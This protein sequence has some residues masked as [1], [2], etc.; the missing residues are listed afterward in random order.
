MK[1]EKPL[2]FHIFAGYFILVVALPWI[3]FI[4]FALAYYHINPFDSEFRQE[5][6][7]EFFA[8][9]PI[10][11]LM[12]FL[13]SLLVLVQSI[14]ALKSVCTEPFIAIFDEKGVQ[15]ILFWGKRSIKWQDIRSFDIRLFAPQLA[16]SAVLAIIITCSGY[17]VTLRLSQGSKIEELRTIKADHLL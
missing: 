10:G 1:S 4:I 3:V 11:R 12:C 9:T 5:F 13:G 7:S 8:M 6:A 16:G 17:G 15:L 2:I 14:W